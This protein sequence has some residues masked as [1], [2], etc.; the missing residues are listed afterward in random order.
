MCTKQ[1][2]PNDVYILKHQNKHAHTPTTGPHPYFEISA[3]H[4]RTQPWLRRLRKQVK[5]THK[6]IQTKA[7]KDKLCETKQ[8]QCY[9]AI[10]KKQHNS[11]VRFEPMFIRVLEISPLLESCSDIYAVQTSC[12]IATLLFNVLFL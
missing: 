12:L 7:N 6:H 1:F 10:K 8:N 5:I 11:G 3:P 2:L 4:V 9:S